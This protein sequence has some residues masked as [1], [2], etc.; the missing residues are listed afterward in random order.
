MPILTGLPANDYYLEKATE[1]SAESSYSGMTERFFSN[2]ISI[3]CFL[4]PCNEW[5]GAVDFSSLSLFDIS[6]AN[7]LSF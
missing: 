1:L 5:M 6:R 4:Y 7:C 2:P 3:L